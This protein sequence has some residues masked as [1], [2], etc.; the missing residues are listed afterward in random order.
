M[1]DTVGREELALALKLATSDVSGERDA[2]GLSPGQ[3]EEIAREVGIPL[4]QFRRALADARA[5]S[6]GRTRWLGPSPLQS[7]E[8]SVRGSA[9]PDRAARAIAEGQAGLPQLTTTPIESAPGIWRSATRGSL[10]QV[11]SSA[12]ST[13]VS[14]AANRTLFKATSIL[15]STAVGGFIGGQLGGLLTTA[16]FGEV[17][18]SVAVAIAVGGVGGLLSGF[19]AGVKIWKV[20]ARTFQARL[21]Q[22]VDRMRDTLAEEPDQYLSD[23][24]GPGSPSSGD[25]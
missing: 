9:T 11:T 20:S 14:A 8:A 2:E 17:N 13:R 25:N 3:A 22:A 5:S 15:G 1:A 12:S 16:Q 24:S 6:L 23:A 19:A 10:L 18:S 7:A 4:D 21:Y